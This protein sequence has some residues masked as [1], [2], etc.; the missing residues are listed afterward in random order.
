MKG[1]ELRDRDSRKQDRIYH[2]SILPGSLR[3]Q[4]QALSAYT[5]SRFVEQ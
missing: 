5:V 3:H 2:I 1:R 4:S